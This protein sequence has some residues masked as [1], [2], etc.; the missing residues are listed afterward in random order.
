MGITELDDLGAMH[1]DVLRELGNIGSGNAATSLAS[2][3]N[4]TV[5]IKV[6][7]ISLMGYD[8]V[9]EYLGGEDKRMVGLSFKLVGD[10]D[11]YMLHVVQDSFINRI[12][13]AFYPKELKDL[14]DLNDM[15]LSAISEVG[16][17][18]IFMYNIIR[19]LSQ[20]IQKGRCKDEF[21]K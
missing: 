13:N 14:G 10:L 5:D 3:L 15:D 8:H 1:L 21:Q 18:R 7:T 11:G 19:Y 2:L 12:I 6:P 9:A 16:N 4:T 17:V 20:K